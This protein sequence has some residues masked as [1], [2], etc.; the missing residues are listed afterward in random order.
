MHTRLLIFSLLFLAFQPG[1]SQ[2]P[3]ALYESA[4]FDGCI[5]ACSRLIDKKED[6]SLAY[7]YRAMAWSRK[8]DDGQCRE[9]MLK[10]IND[11][12]SYLLK[13]ASGTLVDLYEL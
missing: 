12:A 7:L 13:D 2:T 8:G 5:K 11:I 6:L 3:E 10:S 1:R 9:C 4:D